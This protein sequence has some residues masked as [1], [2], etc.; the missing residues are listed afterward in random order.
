MKFARE[1]MIP[2]VN[3]DIITQ[4][5]RDTYQ[6][7]PDGIGKIVFDMSEVGRHAVH[8]LDR[9]L[10]IKPEYPQ[11]PVKVCGVYEE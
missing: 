10:K 3:L 5:S 11:S 9:M 1:N 7:I 6:M 8:M 4:A 2:G